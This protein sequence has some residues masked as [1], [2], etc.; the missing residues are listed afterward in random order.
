MFVF[1]ANKYQC[2]RII[3]TSTA[4]RVYYVL[5]PLLFSKYV[6]DGWCREKLGRSAAAWAVGHGP[7]QPYTTRS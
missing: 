7:D 4:D 2:Y 1:F 6:C 5:V 3:F